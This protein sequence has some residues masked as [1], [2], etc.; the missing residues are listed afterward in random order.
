MA[1]E[2]PKTIDEVVEGLKD[3]TSNANKD[4]EILRKE[5]TNFLNAYDGDDWRKYEFWDPH[6]YTRNLIY[7]DPDNRFALILLCWNI[8]QYTPIHNHPDSQCFFKLVQGA[9]IERTYEEPAEGSKKKAMVPTTVEKMEE[10]GS[11]GY[12]DDGMGIHMVENPVPTE[13]SVTLHLYTPAYTAVKCWDE[14]TG[15]SEMHGASNYSEGGV[16]CEV[17]P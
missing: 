15:L 4:K 3:L 16:K 8:G 6:T 9:L 14:A 10:V 1:A 2:A 17:K 5:V 7:Q 12:I 13:G 11:T